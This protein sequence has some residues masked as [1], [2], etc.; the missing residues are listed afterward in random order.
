[1]QRIAEAMAMRQRH[2]VKVAP[3]GEMTWE[4]DGDIV[5][6]RIN[7]TEYHGICGNMMKYDWHLHN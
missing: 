7:D 6:D 3:E 4:D 5:E 1:M 2:E